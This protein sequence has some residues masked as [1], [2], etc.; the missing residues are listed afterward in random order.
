MVGKRAYLGRLGVGKPRLRVEDLGRSAQAELELARLG[1]DV[2]GGEDRA[3]AVREDPLPTGFQLVDRVEDLLLDLGAALVAGREALDAR[4]DCLAQA[5]AR[6]GVAER[7]LEAQAD[8][9]VLEPL[10]LEQVK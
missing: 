1:V 2:S 3:L 10:V 7:L 5:A 4:G 9:V 8:A 6:G